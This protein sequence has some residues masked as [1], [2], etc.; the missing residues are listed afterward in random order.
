MLC[1]HF[2]LALPANYV[3]R[4]GFIEPKRRRAAV[5]R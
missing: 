4:P 3:R 5:R 1:A 2:G